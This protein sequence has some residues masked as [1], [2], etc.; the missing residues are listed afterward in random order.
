LFE[1]EVADFVDDDQS[2]AAQ[3]GELGGEFAVLVGFGEPGDPVDGGGEQDPVPVV[4][5]D[6]P[7]RGR[8]VG[9]AGAGWAEQD[10]VA[11]LC[12]ER[13]GCERGDLLTDGELVVPVEVVEGLGC[14]EPCPADA[15]RG[16]GGV[17]GRSG[18]ERSLSRCSPRSSNS[19]PSVR[20]TVVADTRI[21]PPCPADMMR[22]ARFKTGPK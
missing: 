13:P 8:E 2:V 22:A 15:L 12:E 5:G 6:D 16:T 14:G 17:A 18:A 1:W 10:D 7:E 21:W 4:S 20:P 9:F 3:P 19:V 11:G